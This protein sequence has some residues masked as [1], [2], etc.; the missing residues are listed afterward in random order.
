[1]E[2]TD[3][4]KWTCK[5]CSN[6]GLEDGNDGYFYCI[7][8]GSQADDIM[9][10]GVADEDF[11]D[12]GDGRGALYSASHRHV[13]HRQ[14]ITQSQSQSQ[15]WSQFTQPQTP[16]NSK[17]VKEEEE[18]GDGVGPTEP[19]DFGDVGVAGY[20]EYYREVRMR[21]VMGLQLMIQF[22]SEALVKKFKVHPSICGF[23]GPIWMRFLAQSGVM[24]QGWAD[25]IIQ[26]S[27]LQIPGDP[28][29]FKAR[30]KYRLE[31]HNIHGKRA[32][33]IW[34]KALRK[35]MPLSCS[36]AISFLACHVAREAVLPTD[37]VKWSIEGH[38]PYFAAYLE[39]EKS[40]GQASGACP[41]SATVMFR[42]SKA[43]PLQKLESLAASIA[44]SIGCLLPPV[45]F[46]AIASRYLNR[47]FLPVEKI[48]PHACRIY[49]W[50]MPPDLWLSTNKLRL[51]TRVYVMAILIVAIRILYD[52]NGYGTWE[53]SLSAHND[54][55]STL[56]HGETMDFTCSPSMVNDAKGGSDS[57]SHKS[58]DSGKNAYRNTS[59]KQKSE[60]DA[61]ELLNNLEAKYNELGEAYEYTEDLSTYL[62]YC[63]DVA[64][65]GLKPPF[66]DFEEE[67]IIEE[68][69]KFYEKEKDD[70]PSED[71]EAQPS[72]DIN[73]KRS[74]DN[75]ESPSKE[76]KR[77]RDNSCVGGSSTDHGT[78][79]KDGCSPHS[80]DD[81]H[82]SHSQECQYPECNGKSC[83]YKDR[84]IRRMKLDMEENKFCYI[85][86]RVKL[87]RLDY[88][89][90]A[91]KMDEGAMTYV[92]HADYYIL[93]RACARVAQVSVRIMHVGVLSFERRLAWLE[94]RIDHCLH[95]K[96]PNI[97][98]EF[99]CNMPEHG[100]DDPI[101]SSNLSI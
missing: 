61:T 72:R 91:R 13:L 57:P 7:R 95:L 84:A 39:I 65:A 45:N 92:A 90:Y 20:E 70:E 83:A 68:F 58:E 89:H 44:Q 38:L 36:L 30:V 101:G 99:C 94:K 1:M 52:I 24:N 63:K 15:F 98:C 93:L 42:P 11:V 12:K 59:N 4:S 25:E 21:Y 100:T 22:Q 31:P 41:I 80:P 6:V 33:M 79:D 54:S 23:V 3:Y 28:K 9:E 49:V 73:Q 5:M 67:K 37:I 51:P 34:Y 27:E 64:F 66:E 16:N 18:Y 75:N 74:R 46:Y 82:S 97:T 40:F 48:L 43:I 78:S 62:E 53:S 69:W 76:S 87:K 77:V 81:V 60:L 10:T 96:P 85:S 8:C 71:L 86:P 19:G 32:V 26:H 17:D 50:S 2:Q 56:E 55:S 29:E 14:P 35:R 88:L 47:L